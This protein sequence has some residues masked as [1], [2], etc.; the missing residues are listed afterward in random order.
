MSIWACCGVVCTVQEACIWH[1]DTCVIYVWHIYT[2]SCIMYGQWKNCSIY[3]HC[4]CVYVCGDCIICYMLYDVCMCDLCDIESSTQ[5]LWMLC[6]VC[7]ICVYVVCT[8]CSTVWPEILAWCGVC[9]PSG[10]WSV[11]MPRAMDCVWCCLCVCVIWCVFVICVLA[12]E[13]IEPVVIFQRF[14]FQIFLPHPSLA[15]SGPWDLPVSTTS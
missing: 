14:W 4:M 13:W 1:I 7:N 11:W 3:E 5:M 6:V 15:D 8:V 2:E 9:T 12:F 10:M